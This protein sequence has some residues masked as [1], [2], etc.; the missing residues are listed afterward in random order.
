MKR[1]KISSY[2]QVN[3]IK[4]HFQIYISRLNIFSKG[5]Y[6][7][8]CAT[9]GLKIGENKNYF[10]LK[11]KVLIQEGL[12]LLLV[13]SQEK[14]WVPMT[15]PSSRAITKKKKKKKSNGITFAMPRNPQAQTLAALC[16][17]PF[18]SRS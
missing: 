11:E 4:S 14:S 6:S 13:I 3:T 18:E 17:T 2:K 8:F 16:Q 5:E 9:L 12:C 15:S 7:L 10:K 1:Y